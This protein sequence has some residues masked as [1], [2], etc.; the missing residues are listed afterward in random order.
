M[1]PIEEGCRAVIV[2]STAGNDGII[3][4]VGAFIGDVECEIPGKWF[5]ENRWNI[6]KE[7]TSFDGLIKYSHISERCL[8]RI[9]D[10]NEELS[11]WEAVEKTIGFV[12]NRETA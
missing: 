10:N 1:K 5:A 6:D 2:N 11:S 9:D 8:R 4:T 7:L 3:V 12:P